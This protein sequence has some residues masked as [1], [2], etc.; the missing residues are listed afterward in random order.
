MF[1]ENKILIKWFP[2]VIVIIQQI[3]LER[4][5]SSWEVSWLVNLDYFRG[6]P[7]N[8]TDPRVVTSDN[9]ITLTHLA[10]KLLTSSAHFFL[11]FN[12]KTCP[13]SRNI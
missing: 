7:F 9:G 6:V 11:T 5:G 2:I 13:S 10:H 3:K 8:S 12:M 1:F 4:A